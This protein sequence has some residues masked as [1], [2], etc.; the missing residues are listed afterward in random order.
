MMMNRLCALFLCSVIGC[1]GADPERLLGEWDVRLNLDSVPKPSWEIKWRPD[2]IRLRPPFAI[3][4]MQFEMLSDD[5]IHCVEGTSTIDVTPILEHAPPD[6]RTRGWFTR[7]SV[8][9]VLGLRG[10]DY[11]ELEFRG[12][13]VDSMVVGRW[14]QIFGTHPYE[15]GAFAMTRSSR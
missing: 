11:G 3:G 4:T 6:N 9:I 10:S 15:G 8:L 12:F 1:S 5:C 14:N 2:T 13:F 7:D